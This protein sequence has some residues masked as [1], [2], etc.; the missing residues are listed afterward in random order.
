MCVM[1]D[2]KKIEIAIVTTQ[3]GA[4]SVYHLFLDW[5]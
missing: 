3:I 4:T 5:Q 2:L 1:T